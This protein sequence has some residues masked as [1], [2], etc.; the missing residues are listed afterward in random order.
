MK[1]MGLPGAV[2]STLAPEHFPLALKRAITQGQSTA[3]KVL[4]KEHNLDLL[5]EQCHGILKDVLTG[6]NE[7]D[8]QEI[9]YERKFGDKWRNQQIRQGL[10]NLLTETHRL[11]T[12]SDDADSSDKKVKG[13]IDAHRNYIV[14]ISQGADTVER[15]LPS[16]TGQ[17]ATETVS[18]LAEQLKIDL[19]RIADVFEE[20]RVLLERVAKAASPDSIVP[21]FREGER[22]VSRVIN[23]AAEGL[24]STLDKQAEIMSAMRKHFNEFDLSRPQKDSASKAREEVFSEYQET[25]KALKDIEGNL[26]EGHNFYNRLLQ[27]LIELSDNFTGFQSMRQIQVQELAGYLTSQYSNVY[28][29]HSDAPPPPTYF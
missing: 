13:K 26:T 11:K 10:R 2:T 1:E 9:D 28:Q 12:V 29:G 8:K 5:K 23:K 3:G 20:R 17:A 24:D 6:L 7:I 19:E 14:Q 25:L 18:K 22:G 15:K 21:V 16:H 4:E 27:K